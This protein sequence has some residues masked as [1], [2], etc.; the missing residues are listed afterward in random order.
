MCEGVEPLANREDEALAQWQKR[1]G[2]T[3]CIATPTVQQTS[4]HGRGVLGLSSSVA[5][6]D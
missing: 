4:V 1:D 2:T 3:A 6:G 5:S